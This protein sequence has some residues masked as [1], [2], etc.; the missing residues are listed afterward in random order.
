MVL[1]ESSLPFDFCCCYHSS[2]IA[3]LHFS[4]VH[5]FTH[6]L[7]LCFNT[8]CSLL[9]LFLTCPWG[10]FKYTQLVY[11]FLQYYPLILYN[12]CCCKVIRLYYENYKEFL[13]TPAHTYSRENK[14]SFYLLYKEKHHWGINQLMIE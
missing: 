7:S 2:T 3:T 12:K 4:Q 6:M 10:Y 1:Y 8:L 11:H 5:V 14:C 9:S 13:V